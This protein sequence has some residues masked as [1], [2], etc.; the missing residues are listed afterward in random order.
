M[1]LSRFAS[2]VLSI[3]ATAGLSYASD[4]VIT[5]G[6]TNPDFNDISS[7]VQAAA[8]GD[9]V[10]VRPG[11][12][13]GFIMSGK[14]VSVIADPSGSV[15]I[16]G[17]VLVQFQDGSQ[18]AI[19]LSGFQ[20]VAQSGTALSCLNTGAAIRCVGI[21]ATSVG[22]G[23]PGANVYNCGDIAFTRCSFQGGTD[24]QPQ[25]A[26][27]DGLDAGG[28]SKLAL[29]EC[30]VLAGA[31]ANGA[32]VG[33]SLIPPV[34]GP[35]GLH[36][37]SGASV[38]VSG[39]RIR[40]GAGGAG[41][42]AS[43]ALGLA[44]QDGADGGAGLFVAPGSAATVLDA[45]IA[46]GTGG[47]GGAPDANCGA[48]GG[49]TGS[50][51]AQIHGTATLLTGSA[52]RFTAPGLL[53]EYDTLALAIRGQPG[54]SVE[55]RISRHAGWSEPSGAGPLLVGLP[56]RSVQLGTIPSSGVLNVSL[57]LGE[58]GAAIQSRTLHLQAICTDSSGLVW[59]SGARPLVLLD[60]SY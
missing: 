26:G 46:G 22:L 44:A 30:S 27:G 42:P 35:D 17:P 14:S 18:P 3:A 5:V 34:Y 6:G 55:L 1:K 48:A 43:C 15:M 25:Y 16:N 53:R 41:T 32:I 47:A 20:I 38:F 33:G 40:G 28:N 10:L 52:R 51:G 24:A 36:V 60:S 29:A 19:V 50:S 2:I 39:T 31:G 4:H 59:R 9:V 21:T 37:W 58:L 12:Y 49:Q 11:S 8:L 54:D 56:A 13:P 23:L 7:A 57:P 45:D